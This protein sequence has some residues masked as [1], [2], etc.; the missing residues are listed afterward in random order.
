MD[1]TFVSVKTASGHS[2]LLHLVVVATRFKWI[3]LQKAKSDTVANVKAFNDLILATFVRQIKTFH[4]D[5]GGE[6]QSQAMTDMLAGTSRQIF[7]HPHAHEEMSIVEKAHSV[8]MNKVRAVLI[9]TNMPESLW[10]EAAH[11]V[12]DTDNKTAITA[13]ENYMS[14]H[15]CLYGERPNAQSLRP[16]GCAAIVFVEKH[17]RKNKLEKRG[18]PALLMGYAQETK[19]YRLLHLITGVI[20]EA[21]KGNIR[22]YEHHTVSKEYVARLL[23]TRTAPTP[24]LLDRIP[25]LSLLVLGLPADYVPLADANDLARIRLDVS[26]HNVEARGSATAEAEWARAATPEGSSPVDPEGSGD[27]EG[28]SGA[29]ARSESAAELGAQSTADDWSDVLDED[30]ET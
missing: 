1:L 8:L 10:D 12:T 25:F 23:V 26:R 19:G 11:Y 13:S 29:T 27:Q 24:T 21:R 20:G 7:S 14:P 15:Q 6:F 18:A 5:Q 28:H 3:Y 16:W 17:Y 30:N 4:S 9:I 2:M 22:F